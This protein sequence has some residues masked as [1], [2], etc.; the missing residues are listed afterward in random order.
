MKKLLL[1]GGLLSALLGAKGQA[2]LRFTNEF[3]DVTLYIYSPLYGIRDTIKAK[4][5][6]KVFNVP[7][8]HTNLYLYIKYGEFQ[9]ELN[10]NTAIGDTIY[11]QGAYYFHVGYNSKTKKWISAV[12]T[13]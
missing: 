3:P 8:V 1:I 10:N 12:K 2:T 9:K 6:G 11:T 7:V 4:Q 13:K 5:S